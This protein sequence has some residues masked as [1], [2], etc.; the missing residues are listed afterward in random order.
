MKLKALAAAALAIP[1]AT[2]CLGPNH[3]HDGLRNWNA[4]ATET[5][6]VN[7]VIFLG[8]SVVPVYSIAMIGDVLIFNTVDYWSG[9]NP[10]EDPG[11]FPHDAFGH[12]ADA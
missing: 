8:L 1:L 11:P 4:T 5:E 9:N 7:E 6:W 3:A 2:S 10:F 12:A